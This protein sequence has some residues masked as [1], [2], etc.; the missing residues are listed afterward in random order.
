LIGSL[1]TLAETL[2]KQRRFD[3]T[4]E[5]LREARAVA[6]AL[7]PN[8]HW[9]NGSLD[10]VEGEIFAAQGRYSEAEPLLDRAVATLAAGFGENYPMTRQAAAARAALQQARKNASAMEP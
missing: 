3:E 8:G 9:V 7:Y 5:L 10:Q 6:A 1:R 2:G 4:V